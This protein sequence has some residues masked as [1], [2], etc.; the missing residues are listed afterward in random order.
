[1]LAETL[2]RQNKR[3]KRASLNSC[4]PTGE[5][6]EAT[7]SARGT[8]NDERTVTEMGST[9]FRDLDK[10]DLVG[11]YPNYASAYAVW[12]GKAQQTVDNALMRYFIVH[13]HRLFDPETDPAPRND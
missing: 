13:L 6:L 3:H 5:C 10:I 2:Q 9:E 11:V 12:K 8:P 4:L 1:M 7:L